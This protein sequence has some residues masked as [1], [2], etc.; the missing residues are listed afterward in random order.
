MKK[1]GAI[2]LNSLLVFVGVL[3]QIV[4]IVWQENFMQS[5]SYAY[6]TMQSNVWITLT[7]VLMLVFE[8]RKYKKGFPIPKWA[9]I[10]QLVFTVSITLTFL[11]FSVMLTP[12]M[13]AQGNGSYLTSPSNLFLHNIV[14]IVAIITW[15]L[16]GD[17]SKLKI[18][19]LFFACIP[20]IYYMIFVHF[21]VALNMPFGENLVPYFFFD[22][23]VN[24]WLTIKNGNIGVVYWILILTVAVIGMTFGLWAIANK[25]GKK[26][27]S[28]A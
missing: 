25:V 13:I 2:I 1:Y 6:F 21:R 23:T 20:P 26:R 19:D 27:Q 11:V 4:H 14:P 9:S 8:V 7:G 3:G 15:C 17:T 24:G 5:S 28:V 12:V 16:Y 18:R 10:V 22:Y